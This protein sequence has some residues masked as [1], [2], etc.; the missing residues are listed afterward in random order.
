MADPISQLPYYREYVDQILRP[1]VS[2]MVDDLRAQLSQHIWEALLQR[3]AQDQGAAVDP[4]SLDRLRAMLTET[5]G[6]KLNVQLAA[7]FAAAPAPQ[8]A[9]PSTQN[10]DVIDRAFP[11]NPLARAVGGVKRA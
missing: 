5:L 7:E 9:Q 6:L 3:L 4:Q 11:N 8:A 1:R 2:K 10:P